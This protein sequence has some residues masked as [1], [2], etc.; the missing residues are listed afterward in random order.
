MNEKRIKKLRIK[1]LLISFI[2]MTLAMLMVTGLILASNQFLTRR[3]IK[4]VL[5]YIVDHE[6]ILPGARNIE[7]SGSDISGHDYSVVRFLNEIFNPELL[8]GDADKPEFY[9]SNRYFAILYNENDQIE[10]VIT[11]HTAVVSEE[12]AAIYGE[13]ALNDP[14]GFGR[15]S[16]YYYQVADRA[17]GGKIVVYLDSSEIISANTRLLYVTLGMILFGVIMAAIFTVQF[18][19]WAIASEIRN[20]EAQKGFITNASHELK[21]PLSV[22]KANTEMLEMTGGGNEWTESTIRQVDRM[23]GLIQNL[24]MIAKAEEYESDAVSGDCD[25]SAA[26]SDTAKNFE[27]VAVNEGKRLETELEENVHIRAMDSQIRQLASLLID[28]AIKYCDEKGM[29]KVSLSR[30]GKTVLLEVSNDYRDGAGKDCSKFF[31]RFYREDKS[32]NTDKG[33][34]GIGLSIA[35]SIVKVYH[36]SIDAAWN[37]GRISFRCVLK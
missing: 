25:V 9:Y 8:L 23:S 24:V 12:E 32:H 4:N 30:K 17:D 29:I 19:K 11:N 36:G 28:N 16:D 33:G 20:M 6:G 14:S 2:S 15:Y 31:E 5:Q 18:S 26:I 22:I 21:T 7:S 13:A 1:F 27:P 34:Y 3:N 37:D 35:E 10:N